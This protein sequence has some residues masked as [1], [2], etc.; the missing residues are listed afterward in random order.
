MLNGLK[1]FAIN[2]VAKHVA[3]NP[4]LNKATNL[5]ALIPVM[6]GAALLNNADW[7]LMFQCCEK[8]G[9]LAEVVRI[10]G[11]VIVAAL[12]WLC[13]KFTWLKRWLPVAEDIIAEA[14]RELG[15]QPKAALPT[16][17]S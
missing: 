16:S 3:D 10:A 15:Q 12:L 1:N 5:L 14:R 17:K 6:I 2:R 4:T 7:M 13:G 8:P 9:S 11:C